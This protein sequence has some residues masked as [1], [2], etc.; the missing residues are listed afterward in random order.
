M[1]GWERHAGGVPGVAFRVRIGVVAGDRQDHA[2]AG[3]R[4]LD[5]EVDRH[6]ALTYA[7]LAAGDGDDAG[8]ASLAN[9]RAEL[10]GLVDH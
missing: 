4:E 10:C 9:E 6:V 7:A 2:L 8:A 5:R 1:A 3:R